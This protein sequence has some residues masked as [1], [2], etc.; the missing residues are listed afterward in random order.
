MSKK[1][2]SWGGRFTKKP[3]QIAQNFSSSVDVDQALYSQDIQGSIA[4][5]EALMEA[6]VLSKNECNKI[7]TGLKKIKKKI[8]AGNFNWNP[9]LED[10]HM[11]IEAAL[12]K[13]IGVTAKKLHTGRSRN[14][15]V[16]TDFKLFLLERSTE[17]E[18]LL[19]NLMK[20]LVVRA[21]G[22]LETLM[23]GFTHLQ[24]AQ[25]VSLA[26]YLLSWYEMIKR[27]LERVSATKKELKVS[28]LGS[29]ALSGNRFKLDRQKLA[30]SL[31]F[32]SVTRNSID[33]V[34]DRDFALEV[35]FNISVM[36][37]HFS[38]ICEELIIWSSSQFNYAQL[39]EELCTGSSIMP[40]KKNPAALEHIKAV[41]GIVNGAFT[42]ASA[43]VKNTSLSDVADGVTA[44]NEPALDACKYAGSVLLLINEVLSAIVVNKDVMKKQAEIG[45][46]TATELSDVIVRETGLSFR[47]A[48]NVVGT[49]VRNTV[50]KGGIA[51]DIKSSDLDSAALELFGKRLNL[52]QNLVNEALD[53][54]KNIEQ[55]GLMGGPSS[56]RMRE[57]IVTRNHTLRE[58][59]KKVGAIFRRVERARERLINDT[60]TFCKI[61]GA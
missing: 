37:I 20:N 6:K 44:I 45:F 24:N 22:E 33:A 1:N 5:A 51:T 9:A 13:E 48:H 18:S 17:I 41:A 52:S 32:D 3:S 54:E 59:K 34:S 46:G 47:M 19:R 10:V 21:E 49:V 30:K 8:E 58:D 57:M 11:N 36:A 31:G 39:P 29:G 12:E 14:D 60:K 27:D 15:Q 28:P 53:P 25:P 26:H 35:A 61:R 23:P 43:C 4:Y 42:S 55:R 50:D 2:P 16:V 7:K 38:R 56:K 40:Q